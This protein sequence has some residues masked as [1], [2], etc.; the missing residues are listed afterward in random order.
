MQIDKSAGEVIDKAIETYIKNLLNI[1]KA[2]ELPDDIIQTDNIGEV[3]EK[4]CILH[5]RLWYLEDSVHDANWNDKV[6]DLKRKIDVCDKVKR[7]MYIQAINQLI[8]QAVIKG[9]SLQEGSI[10]HY[11]GL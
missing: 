5:C 9:K 8:D 7:P 6:A 11:K 1:S 4:L 2:L 10:K 3:I